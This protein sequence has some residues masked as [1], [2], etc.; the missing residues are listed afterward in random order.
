MTPQ[1]PLFHEDVYD[2]LRTCVQALGGYKKVGA[3]MRPELPI[4][5]AGEWLADCLNSARPQKLSLDQALYV[6]RESRAIGCHAG[7]YF[8]ARDCQYSEPQPIEP[9][10]EAADLERKFIGAVETLAP[11]LSRI[12]QL[13]GRKR[14]P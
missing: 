1:L 14:R 12:E 3:A 2:A 6:L 11:M 13:R 5:K 9:D 4:S 8:I 10:D 7:M